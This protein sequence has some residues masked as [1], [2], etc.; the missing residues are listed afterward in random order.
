MPLPHL[1]PLQPLHPPSLRDSTRLSSSTPPLPLLGL[2]SSSPST[3]LLG[4]ETTPSLPA[5][6]QDRTRLA[7][8][9]QRGSRTLSLFEHTLNTGGAPSHVKSP[10]AADGSDTIPSQRPRST[11][12][13][14]R[15]CGVQEEKGRLSLFF[16]KVVGSSRPVS[17]KRVS[18]TKNVSTRLRAQTL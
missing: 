1:P 6:H 10:F 9:T 8:S 12:L 17:Q 15:L 7:P 16:R 14:K 13:A 4:A 5:H 3:H 11:S 18:S 2:Y